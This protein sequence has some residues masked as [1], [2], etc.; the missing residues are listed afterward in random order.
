VRKHHDLFAYE[1]IEAF[2][3]GKWEEAGPRAILPHEGVLGAWS[4][5][6]KDPQ[7]FFV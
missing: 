3:D 2:K 5:F 6:Q 4:R 1:A 7:S